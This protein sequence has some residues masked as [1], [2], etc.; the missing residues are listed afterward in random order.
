MPAGVWQSFA[1]DVVTTASGAVG[2]DVRQNDRL[3]VAATD[4]GTT[5]RPITGAGAVGLRGDN[6]EFEFDQVG[7]VATE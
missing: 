1:V 4:T 3:M 7:V 6:C 5:G 2:I